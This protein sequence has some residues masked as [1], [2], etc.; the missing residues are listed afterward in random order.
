[1]T[2]TALQNEKIILITLFASGAANH[3]TILSPM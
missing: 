3:F 2:T 1:M